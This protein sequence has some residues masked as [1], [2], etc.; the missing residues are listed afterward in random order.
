MQC[1]RE[2][3]PIDVHSMSN[4]CLVSWQE[5][6][7][8]HHSS[9]ESSDLIVAQHQNTAPLAQMGYVTEAVYGNG[10]VID[11]SMRAEL[12]SFRCAQS[13]WLPQKVAAFYGGQTTPPIGFS[14]WG[15]AVPPG[16]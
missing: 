14:T 13:Q 2:E 1:S 12:Q 11:D 3:V 5:V 9:P 4:F 7:W 16:A 8:L 10:M 15:G 6:V